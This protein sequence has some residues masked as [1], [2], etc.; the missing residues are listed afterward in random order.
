MRTG[1]GSK[2][3]TGPIE[4]PV[5]VPEAKTHL[6]VAL[7]FTDED[8]YI[9]G[10]ISAAR[11]Q[12]EMFTRRAFLSQ[13]WQMFLDHFPGGDGRYNRNFE[14]RCIR[15]IRPRLQSIS[16][17]KYLDPG[18]ALQTLDPATY[19]VD[20]G[21]EPGRICT[22]IGTAW[23]PTGRLPRAVQIQFIAGFADT[24]SQALA[25]DPGFN[26]IKLAVMH[27]VGHWYFNREP[28]VSGQVVTLPMHVQSLL[29]G[30]RSNFF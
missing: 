29:M 5:T 28:V 30:Q 11:W 27:L 15:V 17:V 8:S 1:L 12:A 26:S 7:S 16:F 6:K 20:T 23:P 4:E 21:S 22:A 14:E 25:A 3:I 9:A 13:T 2:L 24:E 19:V 10:L 18:G